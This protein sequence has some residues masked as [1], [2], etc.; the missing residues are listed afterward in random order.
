MKH[1][2]KRIFTVFFIFSLIL[3]SG[4]G[5]TVSQETA[6]TPDVDATVSAAIEATQAAEANLQ[7]TV[8]SAVSAT[9][10][11]MPSPTPVVVESLSEEEFAAAVDESVQQATAASDQAAQMTTTAAEDGTLTADELEEIYA[12]YG[13]ADEEIE[14]ALELA[15]LYLEL[16]YT[17]GEE[18]VELMTIL[19]ED[20]E[21]LAQ[22]ANTSLENLEELEEV[23]AGGGKIAQEKIE[24]LLTKSEALQDWAETAQSQSGSLEAAVT[25]RIEALASEIANLQPDQI[26]SNRL[27][28]VSFARDYIDEARAALAD[29]VV[30]AEELLNLAQRG[31][32]ASASLDQLGLGELGDLSSGIQG[33]TG[34]LASGEVENALN[35]LN[36][37]ESMLPRR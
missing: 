19:V 21:S 12:L 34:Q 13:L 16:Y 32:N 33:L 1:Y 18:T 23:L 26:A 28:A 36:S 17:L 15:V 7:A 27:E 25:A 31:A 24:E 29:G 30:N 10:T 37:L 4:C 5:G 6:P 14:Q 35:A 11:A 8:E 3:V 20:L 9:V 2:V 22:Y